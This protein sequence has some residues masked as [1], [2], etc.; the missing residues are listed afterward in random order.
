MTEQFKIRQLGLLMLKERGERERRERTRP[1][2]QLFFAIMEAH[3]LVFRRDATVPHLGV[4]A[5]FNADRQGANA[6]PGS[7]HSPSCGYS[8]N[9]SQSL[10]RYT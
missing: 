1:F 4:D 2:Y 5:L 3:D 9:I 6:L 8:P 10:P 7:R